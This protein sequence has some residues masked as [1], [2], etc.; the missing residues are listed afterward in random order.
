MNIRD[1]SSAD[2]PAM[3]PLLAELGYPAIEDAVTTLIGSVTSE[4]ARVLVVETDGKVQGFAV[5]HRMLTLHRQAP[6]AYLSALV[7]SSEAR[8]HGLGRALV[9]AVSAIGAEWGCETLEL[10]SNDRR[11]HAHEF[12]TSLGFSSES[13]KFRR[14][15]TPSGGSAG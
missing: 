1:A 4:G 2:A 11:A 13:R 9:D 6:V 12:Y 3:V 15:I 14:A 8:G 10:T 7:V 5:V